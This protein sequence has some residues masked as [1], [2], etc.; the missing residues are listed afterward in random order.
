MKSEIAQG[1]PRSGSGQISNLLSSGFKL[2]EN[3]PGCDQTNMKTEIG[4]GHLR[5]RSGQI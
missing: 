1:H 5:S 2:A 4:E 3:K